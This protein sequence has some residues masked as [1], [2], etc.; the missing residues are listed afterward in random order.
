MSGIIFIVVFNVIL[1]NKSTAWKQIDQT[2]IW[3]LSSSISKEKK[4]QTRN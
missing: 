4:A 2:Y 3:I 1:Q